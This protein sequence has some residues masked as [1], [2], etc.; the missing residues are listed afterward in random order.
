VPQGVR[1][2]GF[3]DAGALRGHTAGVPDDLGGCGNIVSVM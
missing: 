3:G 1:M 2:H